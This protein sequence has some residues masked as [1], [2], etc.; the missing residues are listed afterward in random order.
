MQN[1]RGVEEI[2]AREKYEKYRWWCSGEKK[3]EKYKDKK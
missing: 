1:T 3:G 2:T